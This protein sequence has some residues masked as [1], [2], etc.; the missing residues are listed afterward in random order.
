MAT[1]R[2]TRIAAL[3]AQVDRIAR[4]PALLGDDM[5]K[6]LAALAPADSPSF[7][8][9]GLPAAC[10][11]EIEGAA[12]DAED[13]VAATTFAAAMLSHVGE[14]AIFWIV[15]SDAPFA[16]RLAAFG[17]DLNRIIFCSCRNDAEALAAL[18]DVLRAKGVFA[19][20]GVDTARVAHELAAELRTMA[21]WLGLAAVSVGPNGNLVKEVR[22]ALG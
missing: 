5:R 22:A 11:H 18:E 20:P 9:S 3:Q 10:I 21:E 6:P 4:A 1:T 13:G 16:P 14:G 2:Q 8:A 15:R 7:L 17:L 19:E 12:A